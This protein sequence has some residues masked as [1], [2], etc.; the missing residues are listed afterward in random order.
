MIAWLTQ[1]FEEFQYVAIALVLFLAG[2]GVP[3]PED[4]PLIYGG[5]LSGQG[6]MNVYIHFAVSMVFI[7]VGDLSLYLIGRRLAAKRL[8]K[9]AATAAEDAL[10]TLTP[11]RWDRLASPERLAQVQGYFDR[12]GSWSVFFGRF[13]AGIRG[14]VFLTAGM[15]GFPLWRFLLLDGLAALLSVPLWIALGYWAGARWEM[16]LDQAKT[17]QLYLLGALALA[18]VIGAYLARRRSL[19]NIT[20][21][22][23][24][25][26][27]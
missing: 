24:P 7:L 8:Q 14:A 25:F 11:T 26:S 3:I 18:L 15:A 23:P 2:L 20:H 22:E 1:Y 10:D 13:V 16:L 6:H 5:V 21:G 9:H 19:R 17:Y 27:E 12:Y 4:I